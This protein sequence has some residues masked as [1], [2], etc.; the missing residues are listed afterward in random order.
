MKSIV[1]P[2]NDDCRSYHTRNIEDQSFKANGQN[3]ENCR[4]IEKIIRSM[5]FTNNFNRRIIS[6]NSL[7]CMI[8]E[9][10]RFKSRSNLSLSTMNIHDYLCKGNELT[11]VAV[12]L[13][14]AAAK[15]GT[16]DI[17]VERILSIHV[18]AL[19]PSSSIELDVPPVVEVAAILGVGLL[20]QGSGQRHIAEMLLGEIGRPPGPEME[21]YIDRE[22]YALAA[23][24]AFGL[25]TLGKGNEMISTVASS[26]GVSMADEMCNYM[27]GGHK[28]ALTAAQKEK[29]K[30]PSY[31]IREG[32]YVNSDVTSPGATLALGMMLSNYLT[33]FVHFIIKYCSNLYLVEQKKVFTLMTF[34]R[35]IY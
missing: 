35:L 27:I 4:N 18:E 19:L 25:V 30:T 5:V 15:R 21:H 8:K 3:Q 26:E 6:C 24:L 11:R 20:Y 32:D 10:S 12:L 13:G 29:Y 7:N 34:T 22:S 23:G 16:M 14:L 28:R 33:T 1:W 9:K 2:K 31:Q 17:S